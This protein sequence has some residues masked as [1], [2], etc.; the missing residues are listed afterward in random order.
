MLADF[1]PQRR[2]VEFKG[3]SFDVKGLSLEDITALVGNH[4][5]DMEQVFAITEQALAEKNNKIEEVDMGALAMSFARQFPS[6][7]ADV[8]AHAAGEPAHVDKARQLPA[9][10]QVQA[11]IEIVE[12][13]F[14]EVGGIKKAMESVT[15]LIKSRP[16]LAAM[17]EQ[18]RQQ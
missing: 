8:I 17:M 18:I 12:L 9:P 7:V 14:D 16:Q 2:V 4:L 6:F 10:L 5:S 15:G 11:L 13:T 1:S 3:G